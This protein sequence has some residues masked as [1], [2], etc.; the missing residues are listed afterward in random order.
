MLSGERQSNIPA[1]LPGTWE[2]TL[3]KVYSNYFL[4]AYYVPGT[5]LC[6]FLV[7]SHLILKTTLR[8]RLYYCPH[9]ANGETKA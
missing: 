2:T 8:S 6:A 5:M 1:I 7:G 9:L 4:S 3:P